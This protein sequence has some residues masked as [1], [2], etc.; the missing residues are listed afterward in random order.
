[1]S[2]RDVAAALRAAESV[3]VFVS[4]DLIKHLSEEK[5]SNLKDEALRTIEQDNTQKGKAC[6]DR[7]AGVREFLHTLQLSAGSMLERQ[8]GNV[9]DKHVIDK[10]ETLVEDRIAEV[11][12]RRRERVTPGKNVRAFRKRGE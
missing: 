11:G 1:M 4:L 3:R 5:I 10:R 9:I 7:I 6:I 8:R 12:A 2:L